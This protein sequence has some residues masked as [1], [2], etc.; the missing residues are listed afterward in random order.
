MVESIFV[1]PSITKGNVMKKFLLVALVAAMVAGTAEA[2]RCGQRN[3]C[4]PKCEKVC[5]PVSKTCIGAARIVD[6][7][8][9]DD[10]SEGEKPDLCYVIPGRRDIVKHVHRTCDTSYSCAPLPCCAAPATAEQ[11]EIFR[12]AGNIPATCGN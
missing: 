12:N 11:I 7:T 1:Q 5:A 6:C 2:R 8:Y 4:A 3:D 9:S 10:T